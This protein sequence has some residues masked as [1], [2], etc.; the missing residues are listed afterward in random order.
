[1]PDRYG[2]LTATIRSLRPQAVVE[3]GV[4]DGVHSEA[5]IRAM[6]EVRPP[7]ELAYFGFDLFEDADAGMVEREHSKP[8]LSLERIADR[9][10]PFAQMGVAV[11]L[12]KGDTADTLPVAARTYPPVDFAFIDGGHSLKTVLGDWEAIRGWLQPHGV[13]LFDDYVPAGTPIPD[14]HGVN[15]V[16]GSISRAEYEVQPLLPIDTFQ[17][18]WGTQRIQLVRVKRSE[19]LHLSSSH[20]S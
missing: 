7:Q 3:V 19:T 20:P 6:L 10:Q 14:G 1:M 2:H 4:W 16:I 8:P 12:I 15:A 18:P 17:H 5:M 11:H 13:V 9:L